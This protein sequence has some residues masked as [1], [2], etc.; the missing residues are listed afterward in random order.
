[1]GPLLKVVPLER[2]E[3]NEGIPGQEG[4]CCA[5]DL[6]CFPSCC[7]I[8]VVPLFHFLMLL[9]SH[10][11]AFSHVS[12]VSAFLMFLI[13]QWSLSRLENVRERARKRRGMGVREHKTQAKNGVRE[14]KQR[15]GV[16]AQDTSGEWE[17]GSTRHCYAPRLSH[18]SVR[19]R[20][21]CW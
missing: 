19:V 13:S 2:F 6:V 11:F 4:C 1:M 8:G 15:I 14:H 7:H 18:W 3:P 20:V 10:A 9:I 21:Y 5:H 16:R 17:C 12:H